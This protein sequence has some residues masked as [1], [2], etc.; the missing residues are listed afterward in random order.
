MI[1]VVVVKRVVHVAD[2]EEEEDLNERED[3]GVEIGFI[4]RNKLGKKE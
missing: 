3:A 2:V 4:G 1:L